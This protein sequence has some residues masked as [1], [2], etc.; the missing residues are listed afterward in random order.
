[1][2]KLEHPLDAAG[3]TTKLW[4]IGDIVALLTERSDAHRNP[5]RHPRQPNRV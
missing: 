3:V 5:I 2:A 1:M 4:E